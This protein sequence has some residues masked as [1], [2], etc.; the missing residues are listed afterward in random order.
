MIK[1]LSALLTFF[2]ISSQLLAQAP[3]SPKR[4][5]RG[6]WLATVANIDWPSKPGLSS[7]TQ[8]KELLRIFDDHQRSGM[9]AIMFQIRPST[10]AFYGKGNELWSRFLTGKQGLAPF[11]YYDP[12]E[13]AIEEAHKRGIELHAWFNPY[14]ATFDL[15]ESNTSPQHIT[16]QNPDW[17][18][19]YEGKKLFNP[20]IPAVREY[21]VNV[22]MNVVRNYDIDGVHFDDY[23]YPYPDVKNRPLPD[24]EAFKMYG[25]RFPTIEDWRRNNVDTLIQTLNDSIHTAK[26]YVK[27]GISPFGI[28]RNKSQDIEGSESNGFDGYGKLYADARKWTESGWV[29]YINPQLY[30]PFF[31]KAAPFEK[32]LDWW[33]INTYGR[34]LYIG[35]GAYRATEN[36]EGWRNRQQLPDQ[37]RYLRNNTRVQ[38]SVFFSS[39]SLTNN[40]AGVNDSLRNDL[41]RYP[42]LQPV[43][44]WLDDV[45]PNPPEELSVKASDNCVVV[46]WKA[47]AKA[48]DGQNAY[49]YIIYRFAEGEEIKISQPKN[50]LKISFDAKQTSF[51]DFS[52]LPDSRYT[53]VVTALDRLKNESLDTTKAGIKTGLAV[54]TV[55]S[56]ATGK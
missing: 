7:E 14:R 53:Y 39:K 54:Q 24:S 45:D 33:S 50:I 13:F 30:F 12:L 26:K 6:A 38:G 51:S 27:F 42:A 10:D 25:S 3:N 31:Y 32:L 22:I 48:S 37:I 5:F 29:D 11:P 56:P 4:E 16:R 2:I 35:Q 49:G 21:I 55:S 15:V 28:W 8:K 17:F 9:N 46:S 1:H 19:T 47:P 23:F 20:G 34:H 52:A 18:F 36:R 41:Y 44:L 43:M 40:L